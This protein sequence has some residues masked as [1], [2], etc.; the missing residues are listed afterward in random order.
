MGGETWTSSSDAAVS[1]TPVAMMAVA[2]QP[3]PTSKDVAAGSEDPST[4]EV[5]TSTFGH[6]CRSVRIQTAVDVFEG[7]AALPPPGG[8]TFVELVDEV[9]LHSH[10]TLPQIVYRLA[11]GFVCRRSRVPASILST[12]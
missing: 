11:S 8:L 12:R 6:E 4:A 1:T 3:A 10:W 5:S 9:R 7:F 2:R